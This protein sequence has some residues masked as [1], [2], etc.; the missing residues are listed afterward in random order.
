[1]IHRGAIK[2][3]LSPLRISLYQRAR[4]TLR[5]CV[6][7]ANRSSIVAQDH[8]RD[9]TANGLAVC[10]SVLILTSLWSSPMAAQDSKLEY[11]SKTVG[12]KV[13]AHDSLLKDAKRNK[14]L[15]IR[16][17]FPEEQGT[18]P[19]IIW[20]HG[21]YGSKD[22]YQPLVEYWTSRGY[23][24]IQPT[25]SD[26][27][28]LMKPQERRQLLREFNLDKTEDWMNRPRDV[29]F[30]LDSLG[31]IEQELPELAGKMDT[32]R[33]GIGGHSF[34]AVTTQLLAGTTPRLSAGGGSLAEPRAQAFIAI[35]PNGLG[36]F[37]SKDSFAEVK[38]PMLYL[39]GDN[40]KGRRGEEAV[41]RRDA[42]DHARTGNKTLVWIRDAHHN[43][44]GISG[45]PPL[46]SRLIGAQ[47]GDQ[48][49][50]H[51]KLVQV[52]TLVFWDAFLKDDKD[53]QAYLV[54][55]KLSD[56]GQSHLKLERK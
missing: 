12:L 39:S 19:L 15:G 4:L 28:T 40:D 3:G 1:M 18:Y 50:V 41:W 14:E 46:L 38:Q 36:V 9:A 6:L 27:L 24:V 17:T 43:F 7:T 32:K 25:H 48:N 26:S 53:A 23:V 47:G 44:G 55:Y 29:Q 13:R 10:L 42:F 34:G 54:S 5:L 21:M 35:S 22:N 16:I 2:S 56:Y 51:L 11:V 45:P 31:T 8:G 20:S 37:F 33:I 49:D 30:T 52:S